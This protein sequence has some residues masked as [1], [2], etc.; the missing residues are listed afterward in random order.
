MFRRYKVL[1]ELYWHTRGE[2]L[3]FVQKCCIAKVSNVS[4]DTHVM[5]LILQLTIITA[6][7]LLY[8]E[9]AL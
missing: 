2:N 3:P 8:L 6:Y 7:I 1:L 5:H 4:L 9:E